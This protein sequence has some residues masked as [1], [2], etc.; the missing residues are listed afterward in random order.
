MGYVNTCLGAAFGTLRDALARRG[1]DLSDGA[2]FRRAIHTLTMAGG[3]ADTNAAVA[4]ALLGCL[5][6]A[7]AL[8]EDWLEALPHRAWI[9][10][11]AE[12]VARAVAVT[13]RDARS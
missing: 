7:S 1:G 2:I 5:F 10:M 6:G 4:G 13:F 9:E 8:P 3:D 11:H 12:Q